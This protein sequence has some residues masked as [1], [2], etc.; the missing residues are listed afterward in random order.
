MMSSTSNCEDVL[1]PLEEAVITAKSIC[2][3][4]QRFCHKLGTALRTALSEF[5]DDENTNAAST[6]DENSFKF[7][8][9]LHSVFSGD[10]SKRRCHLCMLHWCNIRP[11]LRVDSS[12]GTALTVEVSLTGFADLRRRENPTITAALNLTSGA[13]QLSSEPS[14]LRIDIRKDYNTSSFLNNNIDVNGLIQIDTPTSRYAQQKRSFFTGSRVSLDLAKSWLDWCIEGHHSCRQ[15]NTLHMPTRLIDI[16]SGNKSLFVHST[17]GAQ[18]ENHVEYVALSH[19]W[20]D[21]QFLKLRK[22]SFL[23]LRD[24]FMH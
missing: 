2:S 21:A 9:H 4:C 8:H 12:D 23:Q 19:C 10:L 15:T 14:L 24:E 20:G 5:D 13:V 11:D 17:T 6:K 7:A 1:I 16:S 22:A 18:G 3:T